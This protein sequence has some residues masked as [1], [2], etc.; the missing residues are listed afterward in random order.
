MPEFTV[1]RVINLPLST[2]DIR[3]F[4]HMDVLET[5]SQSF[6]NNAGIITNHGTNI[7][8]NINMKE[9]LGDTYDKYELFTIELVQFI[10]ADRTMKGF[11]SGYQLFAPLNNDVDTKYRAL[12]VYLTGLNFINS[13]YNVKSACNTRTAYLTTLANFYE[14]NLNTPVIDQPM[15]N[16][17]FY[18]EKQA[19]WIS[20]NLM[21]RKEPN[22]KLNMTF[23]ASSS[24]LTYAPEEAFPLGGFNNFP[25]FACKF[26]IIPFK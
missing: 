23:G 15:Q 1:N 14:A 10:T 5:Y 3:T 8:W 19:G 4:N 18:E 25:V 13:S 11:Y 6:T 9:L 24:D 26:I 22:V 16:Q 20:N 12:N 17:W 7:T 21:F 2:N